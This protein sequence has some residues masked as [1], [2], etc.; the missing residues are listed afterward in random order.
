MTAARIAG[1]AAVWKAPPALL[2]HYHLSLA[3]SCS[4]P[5]SQSLLHSALWKR[6]KA[7]EGNKARLTCL[8]IFLVFFSFIS[9]FLNELSFQIKVIFWDW[10]RLLDQRSR[11]LLLTKFLAWG[12]CAWKAGEWGPCIKPVD[13][14]TERKTY[15]IPLKIQK[16]NISWGCGRVGGWKLNLM[17]AS[18]GTS[19]PQQWNWMTVTGQGA[20]LK[21]NINLV[22]RPFLSTVSTECING[23]YRKNH[24]QW[25]PIQNI[26]LLSTG[27]RYVLGRDTL[28]S[29]SLHPG[30]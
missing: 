23:I 30:V 11:C 4:L 17:F 24:I 15:K 19:I 8:Y 28:L 25:I 9:H 22:C 1:A 13:I 10:P 12:S 20:H 26:V 21:K 14:N 18:R 29:A 27:F 16:M 2:T 5:V 3:L 6:R 7:C